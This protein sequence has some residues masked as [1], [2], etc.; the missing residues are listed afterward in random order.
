MTSDA[1]ICVD[2]LMDRKKQ[3]S[4]EGGLLVDERIA[5]YWLHKQAL[6]TFRNGG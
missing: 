1:W 6:P 2:F 4:G 3:P 5:D